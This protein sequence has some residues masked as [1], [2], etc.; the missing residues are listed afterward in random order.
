MKN[1][2]K[3]SLAAAVL[4]LSSCKKEDVIDKELKE[5]AANMNKMTPQLLSEGVRLDSVSATQNKTLQYSY[6][7]TDD[8][9]EELKTEEINEYKSAAKEEALKSIRNSPDMKNFR[10]NNVTLKYV[11]YDKNGKPTTDFSVS[12]S[13]YKEK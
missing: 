4:A 11:Y 9:K 1:L 12:P 5:A 6:T 10:D 8:V 2:S 13:E 7:L 3:I